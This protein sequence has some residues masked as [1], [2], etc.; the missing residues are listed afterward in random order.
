MKKQSNLLYILKIVLYLAVMVVLTVVMYKSLIGADLGFFALIVL[1]FLI[2]I[3]LS[4]LLF[5]TVILRNDKTR[6]VLFLLYPITLSVTF[7]IL[8]PFLKY[9]LVYFNHCAIWTFLGVFRFKSKH[10][11]HDNISESVAA[12]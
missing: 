9:A 5:G 8:F 3:P 6:F 7:F 2:V 10:A 12:E 1:W 11:T 4:A